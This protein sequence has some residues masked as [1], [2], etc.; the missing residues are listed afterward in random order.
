MYSKL[1][2]SRTKEIG[3]HRSLWIGQTS[4]AL[5]STVNCDSRAF[6]LSYSF[7][8]SQNKFSN[9]VSQ[10]PQVFTDVPQQVG[11]Y[12]H[13]FTDIPSLPL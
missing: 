9:M 3:T 1:I 6:S 12:M 13:K 5:E 4:V 8:R 7:S 10:S 2:F 11:R